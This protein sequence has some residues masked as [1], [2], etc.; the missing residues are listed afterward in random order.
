MSILA[1][2]LCLYGWTQK[3]SEK[4]RA[5]LFIVDSY[6]VTELYVHTLSGLCRTA[7][8]DDMNAN[9]RDVDYLVNYNVFSTVMDSHHEQSCC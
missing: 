1:A 6:Y 3:R 9:L 2:G 5:D 4:Y 7:Y 8:I